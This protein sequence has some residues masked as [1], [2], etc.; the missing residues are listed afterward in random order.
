V[1]DNLTIRT[2]VP[3]DGDAI[4]TLVREA[5]SADGRDPQEEVDIVLATWKLG[6]VPAGF[7]LVALDVD[8][9]VVGHILAARGHLGRQEVVAVAPLAVLPPHQGRGVGSALMTELLYRAEAASLP[10]L[11]LLGDSAYYGRFG[12]ETSRPLAITFHR[13]DNPHF[14]VRRLSAY[15][16][17][18][19]GDFVYCWEPHGEG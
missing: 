19:Q 6:T 13:E 5:F 2:A 11:V 4:V 18:Y 1:F 17:S 15:D 16:P 12:F 8:G 3:D 10:L 14:L 9:L 7:E